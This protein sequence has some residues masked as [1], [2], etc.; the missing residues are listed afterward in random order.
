M[1][2]VINYTCIAVFLALAAQLK[3]DFKTTGFWY[4]ILFVLFSGAMLIYAY[5][6]FA[7]TEIVTDNTYKLFYQQLAIFGLSFIMA[8]L[9]V[10]YNRYYTEKK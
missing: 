4:G 1:L 5:T 6:M 8:V 9:M 7:D 2:G 10:Y 3:T